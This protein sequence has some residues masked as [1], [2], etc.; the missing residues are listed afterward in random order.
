[1]NQAATSRRSKGSSA[2]AVGTA[3]ALLAGLALAGLTATGC[4]LGPGKDTGDATLWVTRDYGSEVLVDKPD[5]P[6]NESSNAMRMLDEESDLET[7]YGGEF[8]QSVDGLAG[9]SKGGRRFDWFFSVNGIVAERGSAQFPTTGGDIVWWDYRDWTDAMEVGAVV[10]AYPAPFST[11]YDNH[12]WGVEVDCMG[13]KTACRMVTKQ[14]EGDGVNLEDT[15]KNM[16]VIVGTLPD[17]L[18]TPELKRLHR[19]PAASGVF[20]T[21]GVGP[22]LRKNGRPYPTLQIKGIKVDGSEG[23]SYGADAGLVAAMRRNED[24]PVWLITGGTDHAVQ[25]A[26]AA[27]NPEDLER[28]YAAVVSDGRVSSLPVP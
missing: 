13:E 21:F 10:G 9:T 16:R 1:M 8:V 14:L 3:A 26:A 18:P 2:R 19:G 12:D 22:V 15:G 23:E 17:L 24:P 28:R 27:L 5:L 4:G 25:M 7:A 11:G 6:V 20:A